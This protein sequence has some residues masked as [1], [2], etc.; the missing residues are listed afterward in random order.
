MTVIALSGYY[1]F[2]NAGDEAILKALVTALRR[3][4]PDIELIVFSADPGHTRKAYQV[5]AVS[6]TCLSSIVSTLRRADL[7]VSGGGGLLQDVTGPRT[8]P[9]YLGMMEL[10]R[11]LGAKVAVFAQGVGPLRSRWSR[12]A[13]KKVLSR[14]DFISVR[15]VASACFLRDLGISKEIEITADPVFSLRPA[16]PRGRAPFREGS[17]L[18]RPPGELLVG[19]AL[20]PYPGEKVFD[21]K[22]QTVIANGCYYLRQEFGAKLLYL[23]FHRKKDFPL[24]KVMASHP[25][26]K[27]KVYEGPLAPDKLLQLMGELDLLIGMRLHALIFA[28]LS[29]VPFIAL[30]YDPKVNAFLKNIGEKPAFSLEELTSQKLLAELKKVLSQDEEHQEN[31]L[32]KI[33]EQSVKVEKTVAKI[34]SLVQNAKSKS[35]K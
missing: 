20:R 18:R 15:D 2:H 29:G 4:Q 8:I 28:A 19:I 14:V 27:G 34:F 3:C 12:L 35:L 17:G 24:A 13:V 16:A 31:L 6:R 7:L 33:Q 5:E 9:Y 30:P 1:G 26:S 22:I 25:L 23:P 11:F 32:Q 10:A 21:Q